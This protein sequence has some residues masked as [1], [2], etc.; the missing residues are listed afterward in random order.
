MPRLLVLLVVVLCAVS[1]TCQ[2]SGSTVRLFP[3]YFTKVSTS[4]LPS[5]VQTVK[6]SYALQLPAAPLPTMPECLF[7]ATNDVT[8]QNFSISSVAATSVG[9]NIGFTYTGVDVVTNPLSFAVECVLDTPAGQV[10]M[11]VRGTTVVTI[12]N[13]VLTGTMNV[14]VGPSRAPA[15]KAFAPTSGLSN[16]VMAYAYDA[17]AKFPFD[18][19]VAE[20]LSTSVRMTIT[21]SVVSA[22]A[23]VS[24]QTLGSDIT[25]TFSIFP[26]TCNVSS[27]TNTSAAGL[28]A[29]IFNVAPVCTTIPADMLPQADMSLVAPSTNSSITQTGAGCSVANDKCWPYATLPS[30]WVLAFKECGFCV[31]NGGA[32]VAQMAQ[33]E[34]SV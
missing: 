21:Q 5:L 15:T 30:G 32:D 11:N 9:T 14:V 16:P 17:G 20:Y 33:I 1:A 22:M 4:G 25:N 8:L 26:D 10:S 12:R 31:I 6:S 24:T 34:I 3:D 18:G 23:A 27:A 13:A 2:F 29:I 19:Y 7:S 28:P